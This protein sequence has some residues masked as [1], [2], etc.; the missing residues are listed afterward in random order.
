MSN[1]A[2]NIIHKANSTKDKYNILTF[3]THERYQTQLAKTEH[4]FYAFVP[5]GTKEWFNGHGNI[6]SN[7]YILPKNAIYTG[8]NFDMILSQSKFGQFQTVQQINSRLQLPVISLEHTLPISNWPQQQLQQFQTMVGD[9]N[10]FISEFSAKAWNV[11]GPTEVIRHSIDSELFKPGNDQREARVLSVAHDFINRDYCLNYSGWQRIT[12]GLNKM[13]IGDTPGLSKQ[14]ESV[15]DLVTE[16]QKSQV[17]LNTS[18]L[19][20]IPMALLEAMSCGCGIVTT[21]TCMI[22][23]IVEHGVNG[24]MSNN[25]EELREYTQQLLN[26]A[27]LSKKLGEEARKTI[28]EKLSEQKFIDNW[29]KIFDK[30]Y[31][32]NK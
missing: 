19:S 11:N 7:Y 15:E 31:G 4:N 25:E 10:I 14:S 3:N 18:T 20:P 12:D 1:A 28:K 24:L 13:V 6:P 32:V 16:Y 5:E 9:L 17:F 22:P 29:N 30:A 8:I 26:D 2:L 21:E 23:E 27:E